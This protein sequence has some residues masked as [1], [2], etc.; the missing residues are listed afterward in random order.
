MKIYALSDDIFTP[1]SMLFDSIVELINAGVDLIQYRSKTQ[2]HDTELLMKIC[3]YANTKGAKIII[4]DDALL[5]KQ[6]GANGVHIGKNDG[7]LKQAR[8][9]LGKNAIIGASCYDS[10]DLAIS[11]ENFG[12]S[13]VAFGAIFTSKTKPTA[14]HCD[15]NVLK[16]AKRHL[17]I[18]V[19]AIGGINASNI[20]LLKNTDIDL[21]AVVRACYEPFSI[22]ENIKALKA[23]ILKF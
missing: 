15:L 17:K 2:P 7:S 18:P 22:K 23:E 8:E 13:Y 16:K 10:L 4:N 21:I 11:A 20:A 19:C 6:V 1:K 5:A 3:K 9:I 12:A 14:T